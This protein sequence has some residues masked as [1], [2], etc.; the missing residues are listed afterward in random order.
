MKLNINNQLTI[1][2]IKEKFNNRFPFLGLKFFKPVW[3]QS[4]LHLTNEVYPGEKLEEFQKPGNTSAFNITSTDLV[5]E[6]EQNFRKRYALD[7]QVVRHSGNTW[8]LTNK[9]DNYTLEQQN[10]FGKELAIPAAIDEPEDIH[11]QE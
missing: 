2:I 6:V 1:G 5:S 4:F 8:L 11:E 9:T 3:D 10:E 7:V